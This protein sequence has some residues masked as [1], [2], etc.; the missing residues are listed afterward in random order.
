[1][2]VH[3]QAQGNLVTKTE[4]ERD[5]G[6]EAV[7]L[8]KKHARCEQEKERERERKKTPNA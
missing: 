6:E 2:Q 3:T 1:M 8:Q 7:S 5:P 4:T